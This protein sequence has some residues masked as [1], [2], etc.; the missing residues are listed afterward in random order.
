MKF[1]KEQNRSIRNYLY[2]FFLP[3][4]KHLGLENASTSEEI[5]ENIIKKV[6]LSI[7]G[8]SE[9]QIFRGMITTK[10][11]EL[12][13]NEK[14]KRYIKGLDCEVVYRKNNGNQNRVG[15][16]YIV[17]SDEDLKRIQSVRDKEVKAREKGA[18]IHTLHDKEF[19]KQL[20][21]DSNIDRKKLSYGNKKNH[22][23]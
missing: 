7:R 1:T 19:L 20:G 10:I 6:K 23:P 13:M 18:Y 16:Y 15:Y 8:E 14:S 2:D 3:I 11:F 12:L 5:A 21:H 9:K 4:H 22:S 17:K